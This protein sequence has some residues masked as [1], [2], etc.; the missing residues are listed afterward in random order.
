MPI[1]LAGP[2]HLIAGV[3]PIL[4]LLLWSGVHA[5]R[6]GKVSVVQQGLGSTQGLLSLDA[7]RWKLLWLCPVIVG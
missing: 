4:S 7:K 5:P 6:A 3:F 2:A 1:F